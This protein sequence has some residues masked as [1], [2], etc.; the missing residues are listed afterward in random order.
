MFIPVRLVITCLLMLGVKAGWAQDAETLRLTR[1]SLAADGVL[2]VGINLGNPVLATL[3]ASGSEPVGVSI[4]I[5]RE[6]ARRLSVPLR[7]LTLTSAGNTVAAMGRGEL[8]LIFV[9]IDPERGKGIT[10]SPAYVQ[11]EGAYLVREW[12]PIRTLDAVDQPG[13]SVV[14]GRGSAYDLYLSRELRLAQLVR[15]DTSQSVVDEFMRTQRDVAAGVRQQL[16]FDAA[17]YAGVRLLPGRFMVINQAIGVPNNRPD[18]TA[19]TA[20]LTHLVTEL[21]ASGFIRESLR[22]HAIEGA[23]VAD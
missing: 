22:R 16:E 1:Q 3:P 8:D 13:V 9:A 5:A 10:Y 4:E 19:V 6:A 21:K 20:F 2:R 18:Q 15:T 23:R 17:R 12:S 7:L 14:V 11:I